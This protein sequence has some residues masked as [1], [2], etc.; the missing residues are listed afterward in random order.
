M[1]KR[2]INILLI[3]KAKIKLLLVA[4]PLLA[5]S[6]S[7][8]RMD[9]VYQ[10]FISD[11]PVTYLSKLTGV[12]TFAGE[13]KVKFVIPAQTDPRTKGVLVYWDNRTCSIDIPCDPSVTTEFVVENVTEGSHIFELLAH[14]SKGHNSIAVSKS[15]ASYGEKFL[16]SASPSVVVSACRNTAGTTLLQIRHSISSR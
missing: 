2:S 10:E 13:N 1:E 14:D 5:F 7:C 4:L 3:M 6:V 11:G 9:D 16:K 15:V 8:G 12:E